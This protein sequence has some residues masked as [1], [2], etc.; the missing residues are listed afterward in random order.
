MAALNTHSEI[1]INTNAWET[2]DE[3]ED[4]EVA[5]KKKNIFKRVV[6]LQNKNVAILRNIFD[7]K[8]IPTNN[9]ISK[10]KN[11]LNLE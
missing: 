7:S 10:N 11:S 9:K 5:F 1:K 4:Q 6:E 8:I 2:S 3:E